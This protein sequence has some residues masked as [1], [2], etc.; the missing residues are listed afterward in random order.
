[1]TSLLATCAA[2][3]GSGTL[4]SGLAAGLVGTLRRWGPELL[5]LRVREAGYVGGLFGLGLFALDL[6]IGSI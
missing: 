1:M 3:A 6:A 5:D 4:L 2:A